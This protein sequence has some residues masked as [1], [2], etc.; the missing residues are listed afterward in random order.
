MESPKASFPTICWHRKFQATEA[1]VSNAFH[2]LTDPDSPLC[3][4]SGNHLILRRIVLTESFLG[5]ASIEGN[6]GELDG[7]DF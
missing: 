1:A 6:Q 2:L 5:A 7:A 4:E 3:S